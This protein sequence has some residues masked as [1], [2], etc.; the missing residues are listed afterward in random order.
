M[1]RLC[2]LQAIA[3]G[4]LG[5]KALGSNDCVI[6][7]AFDSCASEQSEERL[8]LLMVSHR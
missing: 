8:Y 3:P 7:Y 4:I 1:R 5:I 2:E 6:Q